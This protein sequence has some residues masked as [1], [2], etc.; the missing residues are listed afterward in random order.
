MLFCLTRGKKIADFGPM[1]SE[2]CRKYLAENHRVYDMSGSVVMPAFCDSHT[3]LVYANSREME[4]VDKIRGL[5]YEEIAKREGASLTQ[6][7]QRLLPRKRSCTTWL[8]N[9]LTR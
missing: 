9:V 4:F 1:D 3:H 8:G 6:P 2:A 5:S 7:K